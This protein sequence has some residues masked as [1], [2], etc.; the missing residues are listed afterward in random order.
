M[1]NHILEM[2]K[3][4]EEELTPKEYLNLTDKQRR[5]I[6]KATP[7]IKQFGSSLDST[8]FVKMVVRW[9]TPKYKVVFE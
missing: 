5:D 6:R 3:F 9:K 1:K 4:D 2:N 7:V 8:D